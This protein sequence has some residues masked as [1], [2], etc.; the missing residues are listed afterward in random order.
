MPFSQKRRIS[1]SDSYRFLPT[2]F[3]SA[4]TTLP[5]S[6]IFLSQREWFHVPRLH[7]E[8]NVMT[9][10]PS[11]NSVHRRHSLPNKSP[12]GISH[13]KR[14]TVFEAVGIDSKLSQATITDSLHPAVEHPFISKVCTNK[15]PRDGDRE[16][17]E[18]EVTRVCSR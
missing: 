15:L 9:P 4:F 18:Q 6:K 10:K 7:Q 13:I 11:P 5:I 1:M 2:S 3:Y 14:P 16:I 8:N 17:H 12:G